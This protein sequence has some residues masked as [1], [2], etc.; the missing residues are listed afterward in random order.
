MTAV[1]EATLAT[2]NASHVTAAVQG[3]QMKTLVL[4]TVTARCVVFAGNVCCQNRRSFSL[5]FLFSS[6]CLTLGQL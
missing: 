6:V 2:Q 3:A 4:D 5:S 1:P